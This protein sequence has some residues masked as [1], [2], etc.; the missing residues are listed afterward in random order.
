MGELFEIN[1]KSDGQTVD[2]ALGEFLV[3]LDRQ[4]FCD[5]KIMK[6][7]TGYGSH[8]RGGEIKKALLKK[9]DILKR[10]KKIADFYPC[11][12]LSKEILS[13]LCE[14]YPSLI[15]DYEIS[16]YNSG[17]VIVELTNANK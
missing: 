1:I 3:E 9:L 8:G 2:Q 15:L 16:N 12:K 14:K 7:I 13:I 11:E 10:E 4:K 5:A 17:V 6:I